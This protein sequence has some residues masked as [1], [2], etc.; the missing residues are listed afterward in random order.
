[1]KKSIILALA[2]L[3]ALAPGFTSSYSFGN[4]ENDGQ[5]QPVVIIINIP[6]MPQRPVPP[7]C[8]PKPTQH[9][10]ETLYY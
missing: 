9:S 7:P 3:L 8:T 6:G 4:N 1:M 2:G 5:P 10:F